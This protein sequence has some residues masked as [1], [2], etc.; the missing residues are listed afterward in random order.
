LFPPPFHYSTRKH[1]DQ[2]HYYKDSQHEDDDGSPTEVD[3]H[4]TVMKESQ[5]TP[6]LF[7]GTIGGI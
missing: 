7:A 5:H 6:M 2:K 4:F 1:V 3:M